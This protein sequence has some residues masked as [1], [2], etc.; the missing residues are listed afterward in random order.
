MMG[1]KRYDRFKIDWK[2]CLK[3][4][5]YFVKREEQKVFD[6]YLSS[7]F[8]SVLCISFPVLIFVSPWKGKKNIKRIQGNKKVCIQK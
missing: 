5:T 7:Q 3:V 6:I 8:F 4:Q 2:V 1:L